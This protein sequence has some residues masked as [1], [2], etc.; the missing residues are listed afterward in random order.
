MS[1]A[2]AALVLAVAVLVAGGRPGSGRLHAITSGCGD[3][4]A[5]PPLRRSRIAIGAA[6]TGV[7]AWAIVGS[8]TA[9]LL[10]AGVAIGLAAV[11]H[12]AG[13]RSGASV[14]DPVDLAAAWAQLAVCLEAGLPVATAVT[15]AA[16]P[17]DG[18]VGAELRRVAGLLV[19]GADPTAAWAGARDT[20]ALCAFARAATRSAGTGAALARV[21][22]AEDARLRAALLDAAEARGQ[23][24]AVLITAPLGLCFLPA[25]LVV[26]IVPVVL[27]LADDALGWW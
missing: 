8:A 22:R 9:G 1:P 3:P 11:A 25:F 19:L 5:A 20:A 23:R 21:A 2:I 16:E 26:G 10:C 6:A 13:V 7:L 17:L 18:R 12:R 4:T 24:A 14:D 27:G 15:A